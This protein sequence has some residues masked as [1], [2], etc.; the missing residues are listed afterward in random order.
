MGE[1]AQ[2]KLRATRR[3]AAPDPQANLKDAPAGLVDRL[4]GL[5]SRQSLL[6]ALRIALADARHSGELLGVLV[7]DI[8]DFTSI[9]ERYGHEAGDQLLLQVASRLR[10][11]VRET[12]LVARIGEDQFALVCPGLHRPTDLRSMAHRVSRVR[13]HRPGPGGETSRLSVGAVVA[14]DD[15]KP[16]DALRRAEEAMELDQSRHR[17]MATG[18]RG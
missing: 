5:A 11:G 2:P 12:D 6:E 3:S 16:R 9:N 18:S 17:L 14:R 10:A 1:E 8:D 7:C 15:E 13:Y 4:T